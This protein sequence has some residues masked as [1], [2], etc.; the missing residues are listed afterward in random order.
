[1]LNLTAIAAG[2]AGILSWTV[3]IGFAVYILMGGSL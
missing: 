2:F 3:C 1:M